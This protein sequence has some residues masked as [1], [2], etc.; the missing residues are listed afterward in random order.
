MSVSEILLSFLAESSAIQHHHGFED[1]Q[2]PDISTDVNEMMAFSEF[3]ELIPE[4]AIPYPDV[5]AEDSD[6]SSSESSSPSYSTSASSDEYN[7]ESDADFA[8]FW[9]ICESDYSQTLQKHSTSSLGSSD[10]SSVQPSI[11]KPKRKRVRKSRA[12]VGISITKKQR[13]LTPEEKV[14][15][16]V[17]RLK[18]AKGILVLKSGSSSKQ[19]SLEKEVKSFN[20]DITQYSEEFLRGILTGN[21]SSI[22]SLSSILAPT[23]FLTSKSIASLHTCADQK[24]KALKLST[25]N[26]SPVRSFD[27]PDV[28]KGIGQITGAARGFLSALSD[29][30]PP[31]TF[32]KLSFDVA[33][34]NDSTMSSFDEAQLAASFLWRSKGMVEMG[35][36]S[37]LEFHGLIRGAFCREGIA[38][39]NVSFDTC[40]LLRQIDNLKFSV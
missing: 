34:N 37:E 22:R 33:I 40:S 1:F 2:F 9:D 16:L 4:E 17:Q 21:V 24:R 6:Y 11:V 8:D 32:N 26:P 36:L 12:K 27:F 10:T 38:S 31:A 7:E 18:Q 23:G 19:L 29:L 5:F 39:M 3:L 30:I 28:H 25:W 35:F 20:Y 14:I 15:D 13:K